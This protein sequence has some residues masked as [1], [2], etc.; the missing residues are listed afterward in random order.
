LAASACVD[1]DGPDPAEEAVVVDFD[2][3]AATGAKL[4]ARMSAASDANTKKTYHARIALRPG[5][6]P[7]SGS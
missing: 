6:V 2:G 4:L 3:F 1:V 5:F 7:F